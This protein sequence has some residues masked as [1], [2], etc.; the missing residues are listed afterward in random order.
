MAA[1]LEQHT[2]ELLSLLIREAG[3][4]LADAIAELREA[5]DFCRYYAALTQQQFATPQPLPGPTGETNTLRLT[6][7]G[8]M[9]C[10]SPWNFPLSIFLGQ[11]SAALA[12]GNCVV[13]KPASATPL[14]AARVINLLH[15]AGFPQ[16]VVQ[17]ITGGGEVLAHALLDHPHLAGVLFTGSTATAKSIQRRLAQREGPI[18]PLLAETGGIN[19]MIVDSSALAEQV[20]GDILQSAFNSAGQRCSALRL[21]YLQED[22]ADAILDMLTGAMDEL[23]I[24]NPALLL[25]DVGPVINAEAAEQLMHYT[26][27]MDKQAQLIHRVSLSAQHAN[28]HYVAPCVYELN[29]GSQL[30]QEVFGPLLHVV[31][32]AGDKLDKVVDEINHS[33]YGLTLGIH[34]RIQH[35][36]DTICQ[37]ARVGN[38]Y[39]N[40]NM[41]GA[42]VGVQPFGGEGLSGTGPKAG[43]P[44]YLTRL[45]SER[46][47]S[48]N[49]TAIGGNAALLSLIDD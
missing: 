5:V 35:T 47:I 13:A 1:L 28:G 42:V 20:V 39:V 36:I 8:V 44:H 18:L 6:G 2:A 22:V 29:S 11:V 37:Q 45:S 24:G 23:Q 34:S 10:I 43:G 33:G 27:R 16:E 14:I 26:R 21:L 4:C 30:T 19:C 7:R 48:N 3:R 41:I 40:R 49:I 15:R 32:F 25:T 46:V 9:V 38:I 17:L 31:R 12:A